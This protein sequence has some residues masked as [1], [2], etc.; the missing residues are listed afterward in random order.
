MHRVLADLRALGQAVWVDHCSH[1]F[2]VSGEL[3]R[4]IEAGVEGLTSNPSIFREAIVQGEGYD[5]ALRSVWQRDPALQAE[6]VYEELAVRDIRLAADAFRP[7]FERT[8][9]LQGFVS[10]EVSPRL[11]HDVEGTIEEA[12][13]LWRAVDRPNVM[14]KVPATAEGVLAIEQLLIRGIPVNVTLIFS[15]E[16][17]EQVAQAYL[18]A[19]A[20]RL[21]EG[22]DL[23]RVRSVASFFVSRVD[24]A[25]DRALEAIGT[26]A[27]L[28]L[29]GRA[30]VANARLAAKRYRAIFH[31]SPFLPYSA[32]GA[33]PQWL[34]WASTSTKNPAYPDLL[35]VESLMGPET[36]NTMP[37]STLAAL[38]DHGQV[39]NRLEEDVEAA[40]ALFA[41]LREVG[42]DVDGV[43][44]QLLVDGVQIFLKAYEDLLQV[45]AERWQ[46]VRS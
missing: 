22:R 29:R 20:R 11:A 23:T 36:V 7:V 30:A 41:R 6:A 12:E 21:G 35:Y 38:L 19:L 27:A 46:A 28:E 8:R 37:L 10:L 1:P 26:R 32:A 39:A 13:R 18:R 4:L 25:I 2:I 5:E 40:E 45:I 17:Y 44:R 24:T 31:G 16:Q 33:K 34:L 42:V 14:I 15:L 43:F 9:G 3:G